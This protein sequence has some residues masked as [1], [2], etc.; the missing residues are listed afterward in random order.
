VTMKGFVASI[1]S[2]LAAEVAAAHLEHG[3]SAIEAAAAGVMSWPHG[4][5]AAGAL[6]TTG[7]GV[8]RGGCTFPV[9]VPGLGLSR[10]R[11][12]HQL[13]GNSRAVHFAV[14]CM[15]SALA[16]ALARWSEGGLG[17]AALAALGSQPPHAEALEQLAEGGAKVMV[18][19]EWATHAAK[20][21]GPLSGGLLTRRDLIE[22]RPDLGQAD[23]PG[24]VPWV[25]GPG[26][27]GEGGR[28]VGPRAQQTEPEI[29]RRTLSLIVFDRSGYGAA[30]ELDAGPKQ[31][32]AGD[33]G[34]EGDEGEENAEDISCAVFGV[35]P[36]SLLASAP[37]SIAKKVGRV[38]RLQ[39]AVGAV[40]RDGAQHLACGE[41]RAVAA[42][43]NVSRLAASHD[44][45]ATLEGVLHVMH[46]GAARAKPLLCA[47]E[48][49]TI[50]L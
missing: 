5:T 30:I 47:G 16:A 32:V 48:A 14:P 46:T 27:L 33:E 44:E 17:A 3:G 10:P 49:R 2:D 35:E 23:I 43:L 20:V 29:P 1:G 4:L 6:L 37:S 42:A 9:R 15:A 21:L 12:A 50:S 39:R 18:K 31:E 8:G 11:R 34:D 38:I 40:S 41:P 25:I 22:A 13:S 26:G 19:G 28:I 45:G 24:D 7:A 36:N